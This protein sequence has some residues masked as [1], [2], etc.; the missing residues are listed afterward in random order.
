M[1]QSG[2]DLVNTLPNATGRMVDLGKSA[3]LGKEHMWSLNAPELFNRTVRAWLTGQALPAE[4]R[5]L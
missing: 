1:I 2:R 3:T 5:P 4:L